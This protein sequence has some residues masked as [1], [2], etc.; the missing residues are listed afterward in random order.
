MSKPSV[1]MRSPSSSSIAKFG[2]TVVLFLPIAVLIAVASRTGQTPLL[3]GGVAT[4]AFLALGLI[5]QS[6][7]ARAASY[8][9]ASP[10]YLIAVLILWMSA[11]DHRE[12]LMQVGMFV[13]VGVPLALFVGQE[14][15]FPGGAGQRRARSLVR[16]LAAKVEWPKDLAACKSLPE[17][18]ALREALHENAEPALVLLTHPKPQV[19]IAALAALEF[20]PTWRAG[21]AEAVLQA[22]KFATE[23]PVRVTA[24]MALANVDDPDLAGM[25]TVYLRDVDPDVRRAAAEALLW[26]AA[27]RWTHVRREFRAVLADRRLA[28]DGPLPVLSS[29]PDLALDDLTIWAGESGSIGQRATLT[30][31][32]H[33]RRDLG[34]NPSGELG[35]EL[36]QL[37]CDAKTPSSLRV[38]VAHLLAEQ[39]L[40]DGQFWRRLLEPSQ[41]SYLRLVAAGAIL[42]EGSDES[43]LEAL[44]E[45]ARVPNREMALQVA[46]I[47][48]KLL[49]VDMGL[50]LGAAMPEPQSK[51]AAEVAGRVLDW[52]AGRCQSL[53]E[54]RSSRRS[55]ISSI[56]REIPGP[57][58][59]FPRRRE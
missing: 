13:L 5:H 41:P 19:R 56:I 10:I 28:N 43:A 22:A 35:D 59:D 29:L 26:D 44:R 40:I 15:L 3:A 34:Q 45:L 36:I 9:T 48:Q 7:L 54:A 8:K 53:P 4:E 23:A 25:I 27:R 38:E 55:R 6:G 33:Y 18:K 24:L 31:L 1:E 47:V 32:A 20:R 46:V 39:E 11:K 58:G 57:T 12:P 52:A 2:G 17:V 51:L 49:R 42:R 21:Q 37:A 16:R 14:F 30:L 50:P